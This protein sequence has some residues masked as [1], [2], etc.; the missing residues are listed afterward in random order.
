MVVVAVVDDGWRK[1]SVKRLRNKLMTDAD[2][3]IDI[4]HDKNI[5]PDRSKLFLAQESA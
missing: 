4:L 5:A 3:C 1:K 2:H